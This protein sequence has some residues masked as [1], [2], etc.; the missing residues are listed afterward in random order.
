MCWAI[1]KICLGKTSKHLQTELEAVLGIFFFFS[2]Q[3]HPLRKSSSLMTF[4]FT[5]RRVKYI[6]KKKKCA[7]LYYGYGK[8]KKKTMCLKLKGTSG[9]ERENFPLHDTKWQTDSVSCSAVSNSLRPHGLYPAR[10]FCPWNSPGENTWVGRCSLLQGI[11][12]RRSSPCLPRCWWILRHEPPGN[13]LN[14]WDM[15]T[16]N[17]CWLKA[18]G[19][20]YL[21]GYIG[22]NSSK[23][24]YP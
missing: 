5:I 18:H 10:L 23:Y 8:K 16:E 4:Q 24:I 2:K 7:H 13:T 17:L 15:A 12:S 22:Q 6:K 9:K 19:S 20:L 11:F 21:S 14:E 1:V 3:T